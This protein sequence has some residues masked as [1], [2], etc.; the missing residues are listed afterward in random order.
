MVEGY[1]RSIRRRLGDMSR[2][3]GEFLEIMVY[4]RKPWLKKDVDQQS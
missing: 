4:Q 1:K 2:G 3:C